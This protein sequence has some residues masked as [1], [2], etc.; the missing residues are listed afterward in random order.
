M[1]ASLHL[2]S[3][4]NPRVK[5]LVGLRKRRSRDAEGLAVVEGHD[6]LAV[7]LDAGVELRQFFY[8]PELV[9]N[10]DESSLLA[11]AERAGEVVSLSPPAFAKA[12]YRESPDGWLGIV[13]SPS[14][15]LAKLP[16]GLR[17]LVLVCE[18]VEKPGNLG[19]M[20]RTAEAAGLDAVIAAAATT[21][22]GNPN[23][24]RASKGT[25]FGIPVSAAPTP[26]VVGW[27]KSRLLRVV[28]ATPDTDT[29]ATDVDLTGPTAIVV[30]AEHE[31]VSADWRAVADESVALPMVGRVNS[32]NVAT[33]AAVVIYEA[34]RQRA[35]P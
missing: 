9:A 7:A 13:P 6:E 26:E 5:W 17:A 23:V 15:P 19:A 25:V 3:P 22:W 12:S 32:L 1:T 27:V 18:A 14:R 35:L 24:V 30:G 28:L 31:G 21:D 29:L 4:A 10:R 33:S 11:V 2:S 20:L 16:T 8:C 34:L